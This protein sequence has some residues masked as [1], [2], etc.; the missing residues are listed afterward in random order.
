MQYRQLRYFVK[1]VEAGSFSR[2]ASLIYIAQPAL[3]QQIAE[4]EEELG[5]SL[6][7]RSARGVRPTAAGEVLYREASAL[8]KDLDQIPDIVRSSIGGSRGEVTLGLTSQLGPALVSGF[9][10]TCRSVL[11]EVTLRLAVTGSAAL[12]EKLSSRT[13]Q[14]AMLFENEAHPEMVRDALYRQRLYLFC[15]SGMPVESNISLQRLSAF[16]LILPSR[17]SVVRAR[18]D[19]AFADEKLSPNLVAE[20]DDFTTILSTV[21]TGMGTTVLPRGDLAEL[22]DGLS[23]PA[24]IEPPIF[25]TASLVRSNDVPLSPAG[26]EV[27]QLFRKFMKHH[28]RESR[29]P[30]VEWL[31]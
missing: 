9:V 22:A 14:L 3:S 8:L 24:L 21:R 4:L 17:P 15:P 20:V 7:K 2:A 29:P 6:L 18:L 5:A 28:V 12:Q 27:R 10:E 23:K 31:D 1:V 19:R 26:E 30:G 25:I 13:L 16:P 11:T